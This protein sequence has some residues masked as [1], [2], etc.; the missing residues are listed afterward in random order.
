MLYPFV[1]L[2]LCSF[3]PIEDILRNILFPVS[4]KFNLNSYRYI[5]QDSSI[6]DAYKVTV[7]ITAAGTVINLAMSALGAYVLAQPKLPWKKV[8]AGGIIVTMIFHG[9]MIPSFIVVRSLGLYDSLWSLILPAA[10]NTFWMLIMRN[11][12]AA[13]P[14]SLSESARIDGCGEWRIL[15][16]IILPLSGAITA[17]LALFYGVS[18]WNAFTAAVIYINTSSKR[19]LQ[20]I[21]RAMYQSASSTMENVGDALPPAVE[22]LRAA[23]IM[24]ATLPILCVYPFLQKF[25]VKG[26]TVGAVKG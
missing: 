16:S 20:L 15:I 25:F 14:A 12:F 9:G 6:S 17:T 21:I 7:F 3:A 24:A 18:H 13:L 19:P 8:M 11:F 26:V 4:S 5:F 10:I 22:N 1:Y 2:I 23:T